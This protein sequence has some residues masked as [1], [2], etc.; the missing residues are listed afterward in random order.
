MSIP[1]DGDS[2]PTQHQLQPV[3]VVTTEIVNNVFIQKLNIMCIL[4]FHY[5]Y[6]PSTDYA[7]FFTGLLFHAWLIKHFVRLRSQLYT[8]YV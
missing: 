5:F 6:R 2:I 8:N 3:V 4:A 7:G 1:Q